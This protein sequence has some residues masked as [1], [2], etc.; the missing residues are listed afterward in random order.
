MNKR[1]FIIGSFYCGV[2]VILGAFGAHALK[3]LLSPETLQ[4]F[5]TAVHYQLTH[6]LAILI[7][8]LIY[9]QHQKG[10]L[11]NVWRFF[12]A[13]II[14]FSGSLYLLTYLKLMKIDFPPAI[15]LITPLG[16]LL[17]ILGWISLAWTFLRK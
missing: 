13:G 17:M 15:A 12:S 11:L 9:T 8:G 6:G 10:M 5:Q 4:S 3:A 14:C 2:A 7:V 16:G 1:I